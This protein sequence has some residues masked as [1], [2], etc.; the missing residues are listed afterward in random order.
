[1]NFQFTF[2]FGLL[3]VVMGCTSEGTNSTQTEEV[4]TDIALADSTTESR[5]LIPEKYAN[6]DTGMPIPNHN[7]TISGEILDNNQYWHQESKSLVVIKADP[8]TYDES[9]KAQS[10]RILEIH[11]TESCE[12]LQRFVLP[13]NV[14]PDFPYYLAKISYNNQ[15]KLIAIRGFTDIFIYDMDKQKLLDPLVPAFK[16]ERFGADAQ[17]GR[18]LRIELWE[19]YLIGYA[20]DYGVFAFD[21]GNNGKPKA[22]LPVSE[23]LDGD[24]NYHSLFLLKAQ[25]GN[26]QAFMPTYHFEKDSFGIDPMFDQPQ[27]LANK[28][29]FSPKDKSYTIIRGKE[30]AFAVDMT[31]HQL[32]DLPDQIAQENNKS[33]ASWIDRQA[34]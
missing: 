13:V 1:M 19:D 7:C 5:Q 30:R 32:I 15:S 10:H 33:V 26:H 27:N 21:F 16:E 17:S 24:E 6:F 31:S 3:I 28:K 9:L 20:Q 11:Q 29:V 4:P 12:L 18:I 14:S 23:W 22:A 8:E 25:N 34:Q 2:L